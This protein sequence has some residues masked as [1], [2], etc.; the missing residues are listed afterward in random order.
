MT[1]FLIYEKK[2]T[3]WVSDGDIGI[4]GRIFHTESFSGTRSGMMLLHMKL[5][6]ISRQNWYGR[7]WGST[8]R[9]TSW[10]TFPDAKISWKFMK[11]VLKFMFSKGQLISKKIVKPRI[12]PKNERM[13][14][15]LLLFMAK[16]KK[17]HSFIFSV[18]SDL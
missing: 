18:L 7:I 14:L 6:W 3:Y 1:I 5:I 8:T 16:K 4:V 11:I 9:W 13:N 2:N 12:L 10:R 15:F 17:N